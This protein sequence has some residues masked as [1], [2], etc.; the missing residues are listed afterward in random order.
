MPTT[1]PVPRC[2]QCG[3]RL[4]AVTRLQLPEGV[5]HFAWDNTRSVEENAHA[6][7]L[8]KARY[9]VPTGGYGHFGEGV[10]CSLRHGYEFGLRAARAGFTPPEAP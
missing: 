7:R 2:L 8:F 5:R 10:F 4:R 9:T 1:T 6:E 3:K